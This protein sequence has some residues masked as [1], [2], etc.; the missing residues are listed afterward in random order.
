MGLK[1]PVI[2][3]CN[4]PKTCFTRVAAQ[5][6]GIGINYANYP[7]HDLCMGFVH[8]HSTV[9][10]LFVT[11]KHA[12]SISLSYIKSVNFMVGDTKMNEMG[13]L[14]LFRYETGM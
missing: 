10:S 3:E 4:A 9:C 7:K 13:Y 6:N 14:L 11:S 12:I 5:W 2:S 1:L 8:L